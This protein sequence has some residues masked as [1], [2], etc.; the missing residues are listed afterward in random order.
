[1]PGG[2]SNWDAQADDQDASHILTLL[3]KTSLSSSAI[4]RP[5]Q[6]WVIFV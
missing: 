6:N 2:G 1:M 5:L 3:Q 4:S